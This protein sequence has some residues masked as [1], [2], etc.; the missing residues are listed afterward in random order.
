MLPNRRIKHFCNNPYSTATFVSGLICI[1]TLF[2]SLLFMKN[3]IPGMLLLTSFLACTSPGGAPAAV[4][5]PLGDYLLVGDSVVI[6]TVTIN[7]EVS[8]TAAQQ[9]INDK[10][11]II[12]DAT[13]SGQPIDKSTIEEGDGFGLIVADVKTEL[14]DTRSVKLEN[15]KFSKKMYDALEDKDIELLINV[16]SGRRASE[17]NILECG[18][19]NDKMSKLKGK[20][21]VI[22][23][24]LI[25]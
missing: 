19:V 7:L 17:N 13:F 16:Y 3:L 4:G 18:I 25:E 24:K 10:E 21:Y 11:T 23:C 9:L 22:Q 12:V 2:Q 20:S 15:I 8:P 14:T 6:P 5:Q 1:V